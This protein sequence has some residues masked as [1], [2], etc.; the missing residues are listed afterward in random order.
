MSLCQFIVF[1]LRSPYF[2]IWL[3]IYYLKN[4]LSLLVILSLISKYKIQLNT[5]KVKNVFHNNY[6]WLEYK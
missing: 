3:T 6:T 1:F 5:F 4:V 2:D